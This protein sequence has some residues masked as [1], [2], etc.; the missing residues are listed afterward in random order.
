MTTP[1][2]RLIHALAQAVADDYLTEQRQAQSQNPPAPQNQAPL[3]APR[4]AA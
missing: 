4:Q 2:H 1:L 3:P